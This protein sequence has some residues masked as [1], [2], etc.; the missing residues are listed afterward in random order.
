MIKGLSRFREHFS[1]YKDNYVL[2]GGSACSILMDE[3][4]L[5]YRATK[6]LDIVLCLEALTGEF[7][8]A[9]WEF[10]R[11]GGYSTIKKSSGKKCFYRFTEP[12]ENDF[13]YMIELLSDQ[14]S[15]FQQYEP[16]SI[17]PMRLEEEVVSLS[18]ILLN[19]EY[20][21][22]IMSL[23]FEI[24]D[25]IIAD[26]RCIIP[27]KARAYLDLTSR[28]DKGEAVRGSDIKKHKNDIYRMTQLITDVPIADIP[29]SINKDIEV[30]VDNIEDDDALLAQLKIENLTM[31]EIK[32]R[33]LLVYCAS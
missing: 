23:K 28:K 13:P 33:L 1:N 32:E 18:A 9:F 14:D 11:L 16:G 26:E 24:D 10:I 30:F 12:T 22:F 17:I 7:V 21:Q 19:K 25:I 3:A 5:P 20:Y 8:K 15:S 6:D 2:I 29:E 4:G 27:L 31:S